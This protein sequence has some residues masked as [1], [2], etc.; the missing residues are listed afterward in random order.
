VVQRLGPFPW[1]PVLVA[2][3]SLPFVGA[4]GYLA[5]RLGADFIGQ[6]VMAIGAF[7]VAVLV[8][9]AVSAGHTRHCP[10]CRWH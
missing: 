8:F 2:C 4:G 10:G 1:R 5:G 7:C 6:V 9:S 3:G